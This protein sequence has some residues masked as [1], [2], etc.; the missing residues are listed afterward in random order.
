M[1]VTT[2]YTTGNQGL[3]YCLVENGPPLRTAH[4][5]EDAMWDDLLRVDWGRLTH[6]YGWAQ[7]M[8]EILRKMIARD[9]TARA[10]G[11][12]AFWGAI[13]HQG[14]YYDSTVAAIPF[15]IEAVADSGTPERA[16]ILRYFRDR[17]LEA[18]EY[19]GDPLVPEPPGGTDIPTPMRDDPDE[20]VTAAPN[21]PEG[22]EEEFDIHAYRRMDLCAWQ[23]GRA[24]QAGRPT[25]VQ[26]L[27]DPVREVAAAAAALLLLWPETRA[28]A[29]Q[30]L[31]RTVAEEPS[32][33]EQGARILEF[34][35]YATDDDMATLA[36]WTVPHQPDLV[37]AAAALVWA[38]VVNP[39]PLPEAA[40]AALR[41]TSAPGTDAFGK[42]RWVGVYHRGPWVLPANAADLVLRLAENQD[43][44]LRWRAVQGL[45]LS[46]VTARY[47]PAAQVVPVL[48]RRLSDDYNRIRAA[49]ALAL[50]QH[51]EAV[52][53][54]E[55]EAVP[56][57]IRAL[58]AYR[59]RYWGDEV[60]G[61]DTDAS[62]CGH[63]ARLLAI[64]SHRLTPAQRQEASA[65]IDRAARRH[66]NRR[67]EYVSFQGMGIQA[68]SFLREQRDLLGKPAEWS[69]TELFAAFAFPEKEDRRLSPQDLDRRLADAYRRAPDQTLAGA[70]EVLRAANDRSA[71][72]GAARWLMTLG[73][74]AEGA[75]AALDA[76]AGG[77]LDPYAREQAAAAS[78]YI[79]QSLLVVPDAGGSAAGEESSARAHVAQ[80]LRAAARAALSDSERAART[81]ELTGYLHH[82]DPYVRAGAA[83]GL[84]AL[85]P[86][87]AQGPATIPRLEQL[88]ADEAFAVVGIAG[89]Y[90]C[91]GRLAHWRQERR[92]PRAGAIQALHAAG[93][94]P[95]GDRLLHALLAE[96]QHAKVLCA[97]LAVPYRFPMALW[98]RAVDAAGGLATADPQIR[99]ARQRCQ[100]Q[101]WQGNNAP[102]VCA[103][104]LAEVIRHLSGRLV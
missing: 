75:L 17:W 62:V 96:S 80:L 94:L 43:K 32:A 12:D 9:E 6:A 65:A 100:G 36:E 67:D 99:S 92:S 5:V 95:E 18:P 39:G 11:W 69:L 45:G 47:L 98:R 82:A 31:V 87:A 71:V 19:G 91:E 102:Q 24:I 37:R 58:E 35:V 60:P 15:L 38:W 13:N 10:E 52:L 16:N 88:L 7:G 86:A 20:P 26:L 72:I 1:A 50:A 48:L 30:T 25:F 70:L 23:A 77:P 21:S 66:A 53:E 76:V 33:V 51:G 104:D 8:P 78:T 59:S 89:E 83:E 64:L 29:K 44:E 40:A 46:H 57:L 14:D 56:V 74:A 68:A 84:A 101:P 27:E 22:E 3:A 93:R 42:L 2:G 73:P 54:I 103:A 34:G 81:A 61:L 28:L 85:M 4:E 63:A 49:A 79:R 41:A 90:A 55:P 97:N